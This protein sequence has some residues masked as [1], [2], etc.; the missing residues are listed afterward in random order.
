MPIPMSATEIADDLAD[1]IRRGEYEPG[2]RLPTYLELATLYGVGET[3]IT[4]VVRLLKDR[5]VVVGAQGRGVFV[6]DD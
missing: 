1:R 4:T 6:V 3:T 2:S 5:G